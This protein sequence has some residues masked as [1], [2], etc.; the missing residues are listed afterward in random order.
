MNLESVRAELQITSQVISDD[1]VNY[2]IG[3]LED[4]DDDNLIFAEVLRLVL[5]KHQGLVERKIGKYWE[6]IDPKNIKKQINYYMNAASS[7]V[8]D[9]QPDNI[10]S[11]FTREG[12]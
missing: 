6:R 10:D 12:L 1:D 5:R 2:V 4:C 9:D 11:F 3:K 8:F 7:S